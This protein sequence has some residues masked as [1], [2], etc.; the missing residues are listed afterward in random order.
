M[1]EGPDETAARQVAQ[2][3]LEGREVTDAQFDALLPERPRSFSK[4]FWTPV[5]VAVELCAWLR[6][7][8]AERLLDVGSGPGKLCAIASLLLG[9]KVYGV[10]QRPHLAA[11]ARALAASLG[12]QVEIR[13]R[14][15]DQVD[16]GE[17]D[18]FYFY[19]PFAE[20]VSEAPDQFD[21]SVAFSDDRYFDDMQTV[22]GWLNAAGA[23]TTLVTYHGMGGRI[24]DSF[25]LEKEARVGADLLRLWVKQAHPAKDFFIEV[26]D[27]LQTG[28]EMRALMNRLN[29]TEEE[30]PLLTRLVSLG[31]K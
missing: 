10:E 27:T 17:F 18:A 2:A 3:L 21:Q 5:A 24:P 6:P 31:R 7:L 12:A 22:E 14:T 19:N 29:V 16:A 13:D 25:H 15:F 30:S 20:H 11:T 4:T 26:D 1:E 9:R 8:R 23:G 28:A